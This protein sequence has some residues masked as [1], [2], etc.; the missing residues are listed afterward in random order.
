MKRLICTALLATALTAASAAAMADGHKE[1]RHHHTM[2]Q[3]MHHDK[4]QAWSKKDLQVTQQMLRDTGFYKAPVT[5]QW[6]QTT[7]NAVA[8]YQYANGLRVT[9]TVNEETA[10]KMGLHPVARAKLDETKTPPMPRHAPRH[11][12]K[13]AHEEAKKAH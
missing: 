12:V 9:G 10:A 1:S 13:A 11:K 4:V 2:R 8:S 5:G 6:D 3:A 7:A